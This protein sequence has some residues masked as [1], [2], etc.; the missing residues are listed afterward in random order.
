MR[1]DVTS[2]AIPE[3]LY[4]EGK[5]GKKVLRRNLRPLHLHLP[6]SA[7]RGAVAKAS[8][9]PLDCVPEFAPPGWRHAFFAGVPRSC[10]PL[11]DL[12][13][14]RLEKPPRIPTP[15]FE[16]LLPFQREK[17]QPAL[18]SRGHLLHWRTGAGK[19]YAS[20]AW[21]AALCCTAREHNVPFRAVYVS[22]AGPMPYQVAGDFAAL[23]RD[24]EASPKVQIVQGQEAKLSDLPNTGIIVLPWSVLVFWY[25]VLLQWAPQAIV[26]DESQNGKNPS[27]FTK[28]L[29]GNNSQWALKA[30]QAAA[31]VGLSSAVPWRLLLSATPEY[32]MRLD[33]YNQLCAIE[34]GG[35]GKKQEFGRH[36]C[37]GRLAEVAPGIRAF[38]AKGKTNTE[39]F[40]ARYSAV[41]SLVRT[42]DIAASLPTLTFESAFLPKEVLCKPLRP[43]RAKS[44]KPADILH[45]R[46][47][48]AAER[49]T[50]W[51]VKQVR[52][53]LK[54]AKKIW[55]L[56]GRRAHINSLKKA[57]EKAFPDTPIFT[58]SGGAKPQQVVDYQAAPKGILIS[59]AQS[60]GTGVNLHTT[61]L[62]IDLL[63]AWTPGDFVQRVG[64]VHRIGGAD[65]RYIAAFAEGTIDTRIRELVLPRLKSVLELSEDGIVQ[66][67]AEQVEDKEA[68]QKRL[69]V[70]LLEDDDWE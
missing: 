58:Y 50:E 61:R 52:K 29:V 3:G 42:Q 69:Q 14:P 57:I 41:A 47:L 30:T 49:K 9:F 34:P 22:L 1:R 56:T 67:M 17:L 62:A 48:D 28:I 24:W 6:A 40:R 27:I 55:L 46:L 54:V 16:K 25:D 23:Y 38:V 13:A 31:M 33:L 51:A 35:W 21:L 44:N 7:S 68:V 53:N 64:R 20:G 19:T 39:E 63:A 43:P 37:D 36:Y 60:T 70:L 5:K 66:D 18:Y 12:E 32:T 8:R 59:T 11:V 65:C 26:F 15:V 45:T 10:F 2:S 4:K